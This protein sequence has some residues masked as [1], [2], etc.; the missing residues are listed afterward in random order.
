MVIKREEFEKGFIKILKFL[1]L[2]EAHTIDRKKMNM[3]FI[4]IGSDFYN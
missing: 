3:L 4:H 2:Y 1:L